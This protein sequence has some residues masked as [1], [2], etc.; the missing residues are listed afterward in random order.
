MALKKFTNDFPGLLVIKPDIFGDSRGFFMEL[1][2]KNAYEELGLEGVDFVQDNLSRSGKGVLRGLH[3]QKPPY[4]QAK[5]VTVFEGSVFDVAVDLRVNSPTYSQAFCYELNA[6]DPTFVYI[7]EG[8]AHGFQ[9]LSET[10]LFFYKCSNFYNKSSDSG[11][12]WNDPHLAIP[13]RNIPPIL[14]EKDLHHPSWEEFES[15]F[16]EYVKVPASDSIIS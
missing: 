11:V 16:Q 7:P 8:F 15:P 12:L 1:Y 10:C 5:M 14:S 4:T 13:W 3:F 2:N 9:V 6:D